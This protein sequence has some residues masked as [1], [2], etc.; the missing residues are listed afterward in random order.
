MIFLLKPT[1]IFSKKFTQRFAL[2]F[3]VVVTAHPHFHKIFKLLTGIKAHINKIE[4]G[5]TEICSCNKLKI[6]LYHRNAAK[7]K[8]KIEKQKKI[9]VSKFILFFFLKRTSSYF[10]YSKDD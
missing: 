6:Y 4:C 1:F 10:K 7:K 9:T 3:H 2:Y 5:I 8:K